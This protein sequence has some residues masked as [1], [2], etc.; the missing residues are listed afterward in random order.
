[1]P[2]EPIRQHWV[3]KAYLR[4]FCAPPFEREQIY[5]YDLIEGRTFKTSID[6]VAVM[7]HFYTL[8][9]EQGQPSYAV[10]NA[11]SRIESDVKPILIQ[12]IETE[13]LLLNSSQR[14]ILASFIA[15]LFMRTRQGLQVIYNFRD[16][17]DKDDITSGDQLPLSFAEDLI[18]LNDEGMREFFAKTVIKAA[19]KLSAVVDSMHWRILRATENYVITS[20]NPLVL[21]HPSEKRWGLGTPGAHIHLPLSPKLILHISKTSILP[22]EGTVDLTADG[23]F[24]LNG[25]TV[26]G[27]EQYLFSH[28]EFNHES[29]PLEGRMPGTRREFG[30][31]RLVSSNND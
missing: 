5:A 27:A 21:Y 6:N 23:V 29:V 10:E 31:A 14:I 25:L 24:G 8:G 16:E 26:Q 12:L 30:P 18:E 2:N 17:I 9:L 3:P 13:Q 22:G 7:R 20:E 28:A 1:M 15:T 11:L 4:A 19:D